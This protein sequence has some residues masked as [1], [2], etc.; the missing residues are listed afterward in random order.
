V[1]FSNVPWQS[2]PEVSERWSAWGGV[3]LP[4]QMIFRYRVAKMKL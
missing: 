3:D 4:H 2:I 1:A